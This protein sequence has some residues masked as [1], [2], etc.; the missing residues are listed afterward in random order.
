MSISNPLRLVGLGCG[1]R[2]RTYCTLAAEHPDLYQIVAGADPIPARVEEL[3]RLS[4][5]PHFRA[6]RDDKE[7]FAAGKLGDI[8]IIGTQDAYHV[9]PALRAMELGYDLLLEKP[10]APA[11]QDILLLL[12]ASRRL[13]RKVMVCHVLRY[14]P[15]NEKVKSLLDADAVGELVTLDA[16]EG[17]D[18]WH[19]AHSYVRGH[20]AVTARSTPMLVAKSC[21]DL[22]LL[23]WYAARPCVR[24]ASHGSLRHFTQAQAPAG[25][26]ARCTDGC[27]VGDTCPYNALRYLDSRRKWLF[28]MDGH[29]N[30]SDEEVLS[31]LKSAPW[32][33]CVYRCE[34]D[35]V[36]R[37]VVALEFS[38]GL[39][40]TFTMTAFDIGR[41]LVVAGTKGVLR[42]GET[43]RKLTGHD[44]VV[45]RFDA[46][47]EFYDVPVLSGGYDSHGGG[48]TGLV[49]ALH[50]EFHLAPEN[51]RTGLEASV[52][53]HLIGYA[54]EDSRHTSQV[55][56]LAT[57]RAAF[58]A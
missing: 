21:H 18:P 38:D 16:R 36:D 28:V 35:A 54:A 2:T 8:C 26:P 14:A 43:V 42:A 23:S 41:D 58:T 32:G 7:L 6:F 24:V 50:R 17:V 37:Q 9:E 15:I 56:D 5:Q 11:P 57:Y 48:D 22:D 33:R 3:R 13:G 1:G 39:T 40:A 46:R 12:A 20:W 55:V 47:P 45:T 4:G 25:A 34:N 31:W 52:E 10:I 53:S 29:E 27:P 44:I 49:A 30:A 51:M 19:Q